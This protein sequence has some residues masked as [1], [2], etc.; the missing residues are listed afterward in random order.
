[1]YGEMWIEGSYFG[2]NLTAAVENGTVDM[3]RLDDM[4]IRTMTRMFSLKT[5][6][7]TPALLTTSQH[8]ICLAKTRTSPASIPRLVL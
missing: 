5:P 3:S 7:L 8:T 1:L 6:I 4:V 2:K